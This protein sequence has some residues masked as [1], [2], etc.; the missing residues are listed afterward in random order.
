M[1]LLDQ[2][3]ESTTQRQAKDL[4]DYAAIL[5]RQ[6]RPQPGDAVTARAILER[7]GVPAD[8]TDAELKADVEAIKTAAAAK[9][10]IS[11]PEQ[12]KNLRDDAEAAYAALNRFLEEVPRREDELAAAAAVK[13]AKSSTVR[14]NTENA[15]AEIA[16]QR[17]LRPRAFGLPTP[18]TAAEPPRQ[19]MGTL[20]PSHH[21]AELVGV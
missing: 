8:E 20:I 10:N 19:M 5:E 3:K 18:E 14:S 9:A 6:D 16:T 21:E 11:S 4:R 7:L 12:L 2:A 13:N 1:N 17:R 15:K